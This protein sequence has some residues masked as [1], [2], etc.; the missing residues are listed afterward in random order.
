M[1]IRLLA[2]V[3]AGKI[4]HYLCRLCGRRGSSLPG[5]VALRVFPGVLA[6]LAGQVRSGTVL[7]TGTN[8]KTTTTALV[9]EI[10]QKA[11][12]RTLVAGIIG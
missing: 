1:R 4:V 5:M 11:G 3:L 12:W 8:G 9:G 2:A 6:A 7:V 10:F